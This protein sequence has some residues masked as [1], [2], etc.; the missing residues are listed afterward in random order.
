MTTEK[1]I[2]EKKKPETKG[3]KAHN[4][5]LLYI[6]KPELEADA[7]DAV[8]S[9]VNQLITGKGGTITAEDRWGKRKL[10]YPI[11][12]FSEGTYVLTKFSMAPQ[13]SRELESSLRITEEVL[14]HLLVKIES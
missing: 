2:A 4:Y 12:K 6:I 14:R 3:A 8:V 7:L 9:K 5:E 1:T 13:W 11:K 10:A